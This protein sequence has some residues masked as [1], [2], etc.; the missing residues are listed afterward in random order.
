MMNE[1]KKRYAKLLVEVNEQLE[2]INQ[3]I[4]NWKFTRPED[5][6]ALETKK[7]T[8]ERTLAFVTQTLASPEQNS[9]PETIKTLQQKLD[10]VETLLGLLKKDAKPR[11][12]KIIQSPI[13]LF[14]AFLILR[15]FA[16]SLETIT[17]GSNEP[18]LLIGDKVLVNHLA[19]LRQ[20]IQRGD[21]VLIESP[22]VPYEK[23]G[24]LRYLWQ[25]VFGFKSV[26]FDLP[27]KPP[28]VI[29]RVLAVPGTA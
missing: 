15:S 22:E 6:Q 23:T 8:L 19:Y 26:F 17:S 20:P 9:D 3:H 11:W 14:I 18:T 2:I 29:K 10:N 7:L 28:K 12:R 16:F 25:S 13:T 1:I 5:A 24:T 21:L 27:A 4:E